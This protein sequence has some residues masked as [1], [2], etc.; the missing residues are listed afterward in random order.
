[1]I[2]IASTPINATA[3]P[4]A[5]LVASHLA[6]RSAVAADRANRAQRNPA[7]SRRALA[8]NT[9]HSVPGR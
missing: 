5:E 3:P 9:I 7:R 2:M 4:T 6:E 1:M 8:P